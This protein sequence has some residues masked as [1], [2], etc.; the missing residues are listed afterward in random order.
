MKKIREVMV[1]PRFGQKVAELLPQFE[2]PFFGEHWPDLL[3]Y[4]WRTG[5]GFTCYITLKVD[6]NDDR[7]H[8]LLAWLLT[9]RPPIFATPGAP[10]GKPNRDGLSINLSLLWSWNAVSWKVKNSPSP[11]EL[12]AWLL[13]NPEFNDPRRDE[14]AR[15]VVP[16]V[17][18][19]VQRALDYGFPYL[20]TIADRYGIPWPTQQVV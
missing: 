9:D 13:R 20:R 3:C 2:A 6:D 18:E 14:E 12:S 1:R 15:K 8:V 17:D 10:D 4:R 11:D 19:A 16:R 7:F 5:P